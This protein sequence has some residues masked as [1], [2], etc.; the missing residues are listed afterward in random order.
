MDLSGEESLGSSAEE[1]PKLMHMLP[2]LAGYNS[3]RNKVSIYFLTENVWWEN[4]QSIV[5]MKS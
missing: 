4:Y 3:I 2:E 5:T 1:I